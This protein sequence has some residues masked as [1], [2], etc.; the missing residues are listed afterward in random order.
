MF[1][2]L[3]AL[4]LLCSS[5]A[6]AL[7]P[8]V[9]I[10]LQAN[11]IP[12]EIALRCA[13]APADA[14]TQAPEEIASF[15]RIGCTKLGHFIYPAKGWIWK[16]PDAPVFFRIN[17]QGE[18]RSFRELRHQAYFTAVEARKLTPGEAAPAIPR[19]PLDI[20]RL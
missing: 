1:R 15:L 3:L 4:S 7:D 8:A 16:Q 12:A 17:A 6:L 18:R 9:E 11:E 14:V 5:T 10:A 19:E 20:K 2:W 13:D